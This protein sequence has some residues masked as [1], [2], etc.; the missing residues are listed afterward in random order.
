MNYEV[1]FYIDHRGRS[2]V[3]KFLDELQRKASSQKSSK[4]LFKK[5]VMYIEILEKSGSR[6][7]LPYTKYIGNSIW[8]LRPNDYRIFFFIWN[9][10][11]IVL[12]HSFR[13]KTRKTPISEIQK[14]NK[15]KDDW[16]QHGH[17]RFLLEN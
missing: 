2:P 17:H 1:I 15:E 9:R 12:L 14:A 4:Q 16:L 13:K 6:A 10:N 11:H 8:E 7:G 5:I 3:K